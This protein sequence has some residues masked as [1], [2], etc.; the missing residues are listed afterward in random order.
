MKLKWHCKHKGQNCKS[1]T[2]WHL[3]EKKNCVIYWA[4]VKLHGLQVYL[5]YECSVTAPACVGCRQH[6]ATGCCWPLVR[7]FETCLHVPKCFT[8]H[9]LVFYLHCCGN[10]CVLVM[11]GI[12]H[13]E[14]W[15]K[16][17]KIQCRP[18]IG[19]WMLK[20]WECTFS[21]PAP[22]KWVSEFPSTC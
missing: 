20:Q 5:L 10:Y 13:L 12:A 6:C 21:F 22:V 15:P 18:W 9:L 2:W 1:C 8:E 19:L 14:M 4:V 11:N 16:Q 3:F 17:V 7:R